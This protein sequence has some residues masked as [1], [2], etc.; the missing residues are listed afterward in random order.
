MRLLVLG[1][2]VFLG[3]AVA[4][5]AITRGHHVTCAARG[6]SG[7]V[8]AGATLVPIDR[9][10]PDGLAPLAGAEFDAVVDVATISYP[11]VADA[12]AQLGT[13]TG[14]WTFVS[15]INVYADHD[16][17]GQR[18]GANLLPPL[19]ETG[20]RTLVNPD[21][22]GSI[23]VASE[24]AV[25]ETMGDRAFVVRP[26][27]IT[28][29]DDTGD[30]FGYWPARFARGGRVVVP[31][32]P[33]QPVQHVDVRDLAEWIVDAAEKD[34]TG[35]YDG[36]GPAEPLPGVLRA[37]ADAVGVDVE[38]VPMAPDALV[39]AEVNYWGGPKSLPLWLPPT[40]WG[41]G[42]HDATP[43]L[44][45]GLRI[46][47]LSETVTA[48]LDTERQLGLDRERKAGLSLAQEAIVLAG[49]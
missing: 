43:S 20:S 2:T 3:R 32:V 9:D 49:A 47:P 30:R 8:P 5:E 39:A 1:G 27:L 22:Y 24:N 12:L 7:T 4:A 41:L 26:G 45:A 37:I 35:V 42:A 17:P 10:V 38:L 13:R 21:Q 19:T 29:P 25:L 6:T 23:K 11:W 18:P 28:G 31:D 34:T 36:I 46:R 14:H 33:T 40:H 48:T 44:A 15:S 16:V